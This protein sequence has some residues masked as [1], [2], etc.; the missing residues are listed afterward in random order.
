MLRNLTAMRSRP[1]IFTVVALA[2]SLLVGL[3]A[4]SAA[5]VSSPDVTI[6][7]F[8]DHYVL[9]G[10]AIGDLDVL[11]SAVAPLVPRSVRLDACGI[12]AD[13]AQR[14]AAHRF[15]HLNLE[16]RVLEPDAPACRIAAAAVE[17]PAGRRPKEAPSGIDEE[18]VD[19]WW[20]ESMP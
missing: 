19:R 20:H 3:G 16:L 5:R 12:V 18:A 14:A 1:D 9:T 13:F 11:E 10:L 17:M 7:V 2:S 6:N 15:R 8:A 4:V